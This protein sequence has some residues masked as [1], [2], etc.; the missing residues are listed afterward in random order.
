[1][2]VMFLCMYIWKS[3]LRVQLSLVTFTEIYIIAVNFILLLIF[4]LTFYKSC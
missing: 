3:K 4:N 1:M 2:F